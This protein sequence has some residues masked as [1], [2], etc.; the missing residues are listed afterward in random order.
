MVAYADGGADAVVGTVAVRDWS[1]TGRA[2]TVRRAW[3]ADYARARDHV[4]GANL[5]VRADRYAAAGGVPATALAEDAGLVAALRAAGARV[6]TATDITVLT[7]A[8]SSS[9]APGGF[10]SFLDGL[11]DC[12]DGV[13]A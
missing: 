2:E 5:G 6:L 3:Q 11:V 13:S 10:S 8:R 1:S 7:S 12:A 4:H 9:R